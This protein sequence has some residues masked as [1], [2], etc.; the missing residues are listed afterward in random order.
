MKP[1]DSS[2]PAAVPAAETRERP[3]PDWP[4]PRLVLG[5]S[6]GMGCGKSTAAQ[7]FAE[8]GFRTVDCDRI[9]RDEVLIQPEVVAAV[10]ARF[11]A[12]VLG[13]DGRI[14]RRAMAERIFASDAERCWLEALVHPR[15]R[16]AWGRALAG[17]LG[18]RWVVEVPLLFE[19]GLENWFDYT[20]CVTTSSALQLSRLRSRG[21]PEGLA[22][23]RIA[24][25]LPL[26]RKIAAADFVLLNDGTPEFLR[27]QV[28]LLAGRWH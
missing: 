3:P 10:R 18:A 26:P 4:R 8:F 27:E 20:V 28:A 11:G 14:D 7:Q 19:K 16:T 6:G 17:N 9:V 2:S 12:G 23:Q 22:E 25:Q 24:K 13:A 15:V 21:V 5:L 1:R